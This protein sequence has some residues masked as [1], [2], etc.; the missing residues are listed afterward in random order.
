[1]QKKRND[2]KFVLE[3]IEQNTPA[4]KLYEK[5]GFKTIS[6]LHGFEISNPSSGKKGRRKYY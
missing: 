1:M 4:V 3:V 5:S 2:I 6:R